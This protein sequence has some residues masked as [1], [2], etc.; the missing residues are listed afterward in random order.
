MSPESCK[1]LLFKED[2]KVARCL[3]ERM[4]DIVGS[5]EYKKMDQSN[6]YQMLELTSFMF[7]CNI[8]V[9]MTFHP[10]RKDCKSCSM[11]KST[12]LMLEIL[13]IKLKDLCQNLR[14][15]V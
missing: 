15:A 13:V 2:W 12:H 4:K 11:K 7:T 6:Y 5:L 10:L 14:K 1:R 8:V 3:V 9:P